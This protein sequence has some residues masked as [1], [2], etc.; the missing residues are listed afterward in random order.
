MKRGQDHLAIAWRPIEVRLLRD[1]TA[2]DRRRLEAAVAL[3]LD[4]LD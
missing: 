2:I 1:F 4:Q 3:M